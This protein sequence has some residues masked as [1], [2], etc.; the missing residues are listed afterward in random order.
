[1]M[2][3]TTT[4][5]LVL[6][7]AALLA[8]PSQAQ[9]QKDECLAASG[10]ALAPGKVAPGGKTFLLLTL[11]MKNDYHIYD[12]KPGDEFSIPTSFAPV[13]LAGVTYGTPIF[14]APKM[15]GKQRVHGGKIVIRVPV[16]I[17]KSAKG[18]LKI[19]GAIKLQACNERGCLPPFSLSL[20]A[21]L[22]VGK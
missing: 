1:M 21:P 3:K 9:R 13:K 4:G 11:Q 18:T 2:N 19:G 5:L 8:A 10:A 6:G 15:M 22:T 20:A 14:P 16:S 7:A 17:S 12:P